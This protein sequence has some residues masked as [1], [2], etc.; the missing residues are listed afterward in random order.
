MRKDLYKGLAFASL[1]IA[2]TAC[3]SNDE[4][5]MP[6]EGFKYSDGAFVLNFGS[7]TNSSTIT[8]YAFATGAV[9]NE[10]F[11]MQNEEALGSNGNHMC[12]YGAKLYTALSE[13]GKIEITDLNGKRLKK[14]ELKDNAS[15]PLSPRNLASHGGYVYFTAYGGSVQRID[16]ASLELDTKTVQVG[17]FPEALTVAAGKLFVNNSKYMDKNVNDKGN[18]VSVID[19]EK[20]EVTKTIEV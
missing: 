9:T 19:P 20:F 16:T 6:T 4:P 3:E 11:Q 1:A 8:H 15:K 5:Q 17:D 2:F 12:A 7:G 14:I 13:S 10:L 18:T